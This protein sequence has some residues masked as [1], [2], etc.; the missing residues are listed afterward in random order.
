MTKITIDSQKGIEVTNQTSCNT[1]QRNSNPSSSSF[2]ANRYNPAAD[3][4]SCSR[5]DS[6]G[7]KQ[8]LRNKQTIC[9]DYDL[10]PKFGVFKHKTEI[11]NQ[12]TINQAQSSLTSA[13]QEKAITPS[14]FF[15]IPNTRSPFPDF[16]SK[17]PPEDKN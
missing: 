1:I 4:K 10:R 9:L 15:N 6:I 17:L 12:K 13:K 7:N 11:I 16:G 2:G 3:D 5:N 8:T 14:W